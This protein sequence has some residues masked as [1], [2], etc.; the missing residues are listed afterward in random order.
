MTT[1]DEFRPG[2]RRKP[3]PKKP[4]WEP[5]TRDHLAHAQLLCFDP[6]L[7]A[8]G[9]VAL[10]HNA[11]GLVVVTAAQMA[12][13]V[14]DGLTGWEQDMAMAE[15]LEDQLE[16]LAARYSCHEWQVVTETPPLGGGKINPT[17]SSIACKTIRSV[18]RRRR[19]PLLPM[20]GAQSHR[21]ANVGDPKL[22]KVAY[23]RLLAPVLD[24]LL[25]QG[26]ALIT[27]ESK[28]DAVAVGLAALRRMEGR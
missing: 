2:V 4:V 15:S 1:L 22:T 3:T 17:S 25:T 10:T 11:D 19:F 28:R 21:K 24:E 26:R 12:G 9:F 6:S 14:P 7:S 5:L 16:G 8:T 13:V 23:H 20:V 18:F 27:N